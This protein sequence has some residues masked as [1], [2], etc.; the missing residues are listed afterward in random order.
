[1]RVLEK[2]PTVD[3]NIVWEPRKEAKGVRYSPG[4]L[5][6]IY[7]EDLFALFRIKPPINKAGIPQNILSFVLLHSIQHIITTLSR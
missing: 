3:Q 1:M 5:L 4:I 6:P 7:A 2:A